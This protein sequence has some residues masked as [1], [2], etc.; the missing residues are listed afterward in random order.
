MLQLQVA[1]KTLQGS[2]VGLT[3]QGGQKVKRFFLTAHIC[4][5]RNRINLHEFYKLKIRKTGLLV[6]DSACH[7][8]GIDK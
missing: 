1:V 4:K 5:N 3:L 7:P 2:W 8:F 6:A